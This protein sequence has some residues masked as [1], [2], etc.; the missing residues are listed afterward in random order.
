MALIWL[1]MVFKWLN[2]TSHLLRDGNWISG[3]DLMGGEL[4]KDA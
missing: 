1:Y 3:Y 2:Y 4:E